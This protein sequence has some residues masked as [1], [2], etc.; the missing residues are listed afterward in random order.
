MEIITEDD[1]L[2]LY[3]HDCDGRLREIIK[4]ENKH[5]VRVKS[6]TKITMGS[7][8]SPVETLFFANRQTWDGHKTPM[9]E[10]VVFATMTGKHG[11][12]M[13]FDFLKPMISLTPLSDFECADNLD[14][15]YHWDII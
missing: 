10:M 5:F 12:F 4:L 7:V 13:R 11:L 9:S 6:D 14:S 1:G 2:N 3:F 8:Y 15:G